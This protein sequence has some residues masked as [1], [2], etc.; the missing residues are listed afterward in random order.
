MHPLLI[1]ARHEGTPLCAGDTAAFLWEGEQPPRLLA[2]FTNWAPERSPAWTPVAEELWATTVTL[3]PDAYAEY[4]FL[5]DE[6]HVPD[7]LNARSI[8][9]SLGGRNS[10]FYMPGGGPTPL[11]QRTPGVPHG[12]LTRHVVEGGIFTAEKKR[13]V[14]LYQP[15]T[16]APVPLLVVFDGPD[17]VHHA[18]LITIVEHLIALG[19]MRPIALALVNHGGAT[20]FTEYACS[21]STVAFLLSVVVPLARAQLN[22]IDVCDAPGAYGVLGA[23]MGGLMA[24]YA[25]LRAPQTF[26][27]VLSQSGTFGLAMGSYESVVLDLVRHAPVQPVRVWMDCGVFELLLSANRGLSMLL[28]EKGYD[29]VYREYSGGHNYPAWRNDVWRGLE[30]LFAPQ[31]GVPAPSLAEHLAGER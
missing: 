11:I 29:V 31:S 8:R 17:Y 13:R 25:A 7:P 16:D 3:P 4:A 22:L 23:S 6:Q 5:A 20:R 10:Y 21:D 18:R 2:D 24:L 12:R 27:H 15:P 9:T 28:R 19:R 30:Q 1:R 26:G 14:M